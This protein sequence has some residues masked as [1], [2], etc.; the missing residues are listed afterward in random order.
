MP[1]PPLPIMLRSFISIV[2]ATRPAAV[3][4]TEHVLERDAHVGEEHLVEVRDAGGLAQRPHVDPGAVHVDQEV[5]DAAVLRHVDVG[6]GDQ[7]RRSRAW[8][9]PEF[10]TFWPLTTNS[11]PS[12]T[13][14][15]VSPARSEPAPGSEKSWHQISSP[16]SIGGM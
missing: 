15:V 4:R 2:C 6:A 9:A 16:R 7:R 1:I 14:R 3:D 5:G 13:A 8:C 11:S 12:R 10:H